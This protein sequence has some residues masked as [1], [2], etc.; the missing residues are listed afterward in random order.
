MT[1]N[2][3][4]PNSSKSVTATTSDGSHSLTSEKG[5]TKKVSATKVHSLPD[6]PKLPSPTLGQV[7]INY[8]TGGR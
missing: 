1:Q 8:N 5:K 7:S 4:L 2:Q 3:H 6:E